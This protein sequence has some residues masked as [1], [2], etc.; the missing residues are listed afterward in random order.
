MKSFK[1]AI[2]IMISTC[3]VGSFN[4]PC[5]AADN[6]FKTVYEDSL[7]GGLAGTLVGAAFM[8]FTEKPADHVDYVIYGAAGGVLVGAAYGL[9]GT[10]KSLAEV[11]RG[12]VKFAFPTVTTSL[13][14][15]NSKGQVAF[16]FRAQLIRGTF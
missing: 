15:A 5:L 7:Y 4:A 16:M 12:R 14:E 11:E 10:T 2:A 9:Y 13:Q 1:R 8:A 3:V 6:V